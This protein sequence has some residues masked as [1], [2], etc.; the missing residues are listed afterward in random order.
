MPRLPK[1]PKAKF[2]IGRLFAVATMRLEDALEPATAGQNPRLTVPQQRL[3]LRRL[4]HAIERCNAACDDIR[5]ALDSEQG[6]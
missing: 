3:A 2:P 1:G 6:E 4:A 5:I